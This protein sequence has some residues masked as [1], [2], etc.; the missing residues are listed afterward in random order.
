MLWFQKPNFHREIQLNNNIELNQSSNVLDKGIRH[1]TIVRRQR[2]ADNR[3]Y[4]IE[5]KRVKL[6]KPDIF[7]Q[8]QKLY[9]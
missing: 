4:T 6:L 9:E 5:D 7:I 8:Q 1:N 3:I 2:L